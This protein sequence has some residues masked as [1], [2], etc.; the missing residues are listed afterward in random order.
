MGTWEFSR[1]SEVG[2]GTDTQEMEKV[3]GNLSG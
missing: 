2:P 3:L 1:V